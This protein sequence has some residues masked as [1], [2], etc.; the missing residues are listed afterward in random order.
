MLYVPGARVIKPPLPQEEIAEMIWELSD[1]PLPLGEREHVLV[2]LEGS[3]GGAAS[4]GLT[5]ALEERR[6]RFPRMR[7]KAL[8][9]FPPLPMNMSGPG[10]N[11]L[12]RK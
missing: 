5:E 9:M 10:P 1:T 4:F 7:L 3:F 8:Y 2:N 12:E 11:V 6:T